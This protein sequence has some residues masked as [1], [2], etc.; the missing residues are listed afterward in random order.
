MADTD[1]SWTPPVHGQA[2]P[3]AMARTGQR[4]GHEGRCVGGPGA[5]PE[6]ARAWR[7]PRENA[8]IPE[9]VAGPDV[10]ALKLLFAVSKG[11]VLKRRA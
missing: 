2:Q 8:A 4:E 10:A 3:M 5:G 7:S 6:T 11:F 9:A 1:R